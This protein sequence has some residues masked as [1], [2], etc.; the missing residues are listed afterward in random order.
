MF[1]NLELFMKTNQLSM[2]PSSKDYNISM[3]VNM[4]GHHG[5]LYI[6]TTNMQSLV[7]VYCKYVQVKLVDVCYL[8]AL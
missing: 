8:Q 4:D 7:R 5:G 1:V 3:C 6:S 2:C